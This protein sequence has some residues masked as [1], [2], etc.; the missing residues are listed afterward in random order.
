MCRNVPRVRTLQMYKRVKV[1]YASQWYMYK[2]EI[3]VGKKIKIPLSLGNSNKSTH[4][5]QKI[6]FYR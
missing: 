1:F 3:L 5:V 2:P 4:Q 6:I